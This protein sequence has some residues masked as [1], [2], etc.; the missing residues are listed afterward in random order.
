MKKKFYY[1][2]PVIGMI[3]LNACSLQEEI[4]T[5]NQSKKADLQ[6]RETGMIVKP[7]VADLDISNEK[8]SVVYIADLK[9]PL[10]NINDNTMQL[11]LETY[12]CDY[13]IDP[14]FVRKT[15]VNNSK[16]KQIEVTLTGFPATYKK[17]YQVDSLPKSITEY[18]NINL[19]IKTTDYMSLYQADE[20][21]SNLGME[22]YLGTS[23]VGSQIDF[24]PKVKGAHFYLSFEQHMNESAG[25]KYRGFNDN[26]ATEYDATY[27]SLRVFSLGVFFEKEILRNIRLR[28][29]GGLNYA[30]VLFDNSIQNSV[31]ETIVDGVHSVGLRF[32]A[33][34]DYSLTRGF[35]VIGR[36]HSNLGLFNSLKES[37]EFVLQDYSNISISNFPLV[38][39]G[40]GIRYSF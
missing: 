18:A 39:L 7:V 25:V 17:I 12:K 40:L 2:L 29:L 21:G 8:K 20:R 16:L 30:Y 28:G 27:S 6:V 34:I 33:S 13:I 38:N 22:F 31:Y 14:K 35:S 15:T 32:G 11:F 37:G 10:N 5:R 9:I 26:I 4:V 23:F 1:L 24:A 3:A 36:A 19:P